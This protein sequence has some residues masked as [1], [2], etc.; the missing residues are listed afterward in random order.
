MSD[1]YA[2][3]F[4]EYIEYEHDISQTGRFPNHIETDSFVL[5]PL[6]E[7]ENVSRRELFEIYE[8][9]EGTDS[10]FDTRVGLPTNYDEFCDFLSNLEKAAN[11]GEDFFY[12]IYSPES[13]EFMGQATIED[14]DW[15]LKRCSIGIW[16]RKEFWG[17]GVSQKRAEALLY[18]IFDDLGLE[19]VE[20]RVVPENE[21]SIKAVEKYLSEFGGQFNGVQRRATF[22]PEGEPHD[23]AMY[24]ITQEEFFSDSKTPK[25]ELSGLVD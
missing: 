5:R 14:V 24:S 8:E 6:T 17:Y 2:P 23:L 3:I 20:I 15:D 1:S 13:M 12:A 18:T 25:S 19:L 10:Y 4:N 21:N 7:F 22:T 16:L 11:Q 9:N